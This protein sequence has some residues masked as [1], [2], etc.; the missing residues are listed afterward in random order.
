MSSA[1]AAPKWDIVP[2]GACSAILTPLVGGNTEAGKLG[3]QGAKKLAEGAGAVVDAGKKA[4][5]DALES[6]VVKPMADGAKDFANQI[7]KTSLTWWLTTPSVQVKDS[8]V[9]ATKDVKT[10]GGG[11]VKFSLQAICLGVGQMIAVLLVMGQGI[12]AI[13]QRKGKPLAD[14]VKGLVVNALVCT[15]GVVVID[16]MLLASDQLTVAIVDGAFDGTDVL[17]DKMIKMLIPV[18]GFNPFALLLMALI[19]AL[20]GVVQFCMLF[21]R[22]A[23]IPIQALLLPIAGS[24]QIGG[25]KSRQ[26]LP[27]LYTSI[28]TVIAYKPCAALIIC[29]GFV[30]MQ[31]STALVD[32]MRGLVTLALSVIALKSLMG[33]FAP[34]GAATAG[35][36]AGGFAGALSGVASSVM[37]SR[38]GGGGGGGE[39]A[40]AVNHAAAMAKG[41]PAGG[42]GT[43]AAA[44]NPATAAA[45]AGVGAVQAAKDKAGGA[46]GQDGGGVPQQTRQGQD[47][48]KGK[49]GQDGG[50]SSASTTGADGGGPGGSG[51]T[52]NAAAAPRSTG[53]VNVAIVAAEA[54]RQAAKGAGSTMS[55]GSQNP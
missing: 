4:V 14:A 37:M 54:G 44:A 25:E 18:G 34:L 53:G 28:F 31:N 7:V 24:G 41:G 1:S 52:P 43:A 6:T 8:G 12:R 3:C 2:K 33:L 20:I 17:S 23:A 19:V 45:A 16:S 21:V 36:T 26:W 48:G 32:W 13:V 29:A 50:S 39:P 49:G 51:S 27:R 40:S 35:A 38:G 55:E 11:T 15:V 47:Q 42:G 30:E 9:M 5:S 10:E 22:Q 46:M